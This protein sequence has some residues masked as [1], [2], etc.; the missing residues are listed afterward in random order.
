MPLEV[1]Y[2]PSQNYLGACQ[3]IY[4][5][6][7]LS[8]WVNMS[9]FTVWKPGPTIWGN[10]WKKQTKSQKSKQTYIIYGEY[11]AFVYIPVLPAYYE[12]EVERVSFSC[13]IFCFTFS[14]GRENRLFRCSFVYLL[15]LSE[16][17]VTK[18]LFSCFGMTFLFCYVNNCKVYI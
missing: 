15:A 3:V 16:I 13:L 10:F 14:I 6:T 8:C 18:L 12:I 9:V 1:C 2:Y 4:C 5:K 17:A 7:M 11:I